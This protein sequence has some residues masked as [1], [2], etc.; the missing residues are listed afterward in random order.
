MA[1]SNALYIHQVIDHMK[2]HQIISSPFLFLLFSQPINY[3]LYYIAHSQIYNP[4]ISILSSLN[5]SLVLNNMADALVSVVLE[6]LSSIVYQEVGQEVRLVVGV[7][8]E[9]EKLTNNFQ[10]IQAVFADVEERQLK[11]QLVK[12]WV[13]QLKDVSYDMDDILDEWGTTIAK[14]KMKVNEC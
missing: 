10:A 7:D 4:F 3:S 9:V 8:N 14:S 1:F 6:Q 2:H 12:H 13:D 11:D 5:H